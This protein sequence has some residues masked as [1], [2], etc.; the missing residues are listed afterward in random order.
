MAELEE[1]ELPSF[2]ECERCGA[3]FPIEELLMISVF[4]EEPKIT[5]VRCLLYFVGD[6]LNNV[7]LYDDENN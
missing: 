2:A 1:F 7:C 5:C 6:F 3:S 4:G